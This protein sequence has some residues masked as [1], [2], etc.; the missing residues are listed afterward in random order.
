MVS[1]PTGPAIHVTRVAER[2]FRCAVR[3]HAIL[4][5]RP[6]EEGGADR[7]PTSGELLL[8]AV[9]SCAAGSLRRH[10]TERG[11]GTDFSVVVTLLD[12]VPAGPRPI[13]IALTL[14]AGLSPDD[15][16]AARA[17]ALTGGVVGRLSER[18]NIEVVVA[19]E[20]AREE[21]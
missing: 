21:S 9:G 10:L 12:A 13:R 15:I 17:S 6:A 20:G 5:D 1:P 7:G 11:G 14:P 4:T 16:E 2:T 19:P 18:S 3:G 8:M